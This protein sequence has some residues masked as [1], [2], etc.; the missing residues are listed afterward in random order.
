[1]LKVRQRKEHTNTVDLT[2]SH[3]GRNGASILTE[4]DLF[5][6]GLFPLPIDHISLLR[7]SL[8]CSFVSSMIKVAVF[9]L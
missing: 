8:E 9:V 6:N 2:N 1:M 4:E 3:G 5:L 7:H